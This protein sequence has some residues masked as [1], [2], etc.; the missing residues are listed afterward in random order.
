VVVADGPFRGLN[1]IYGGTSAHER[2]LVLVNVLGASCPGEIAA[3]LV[4]AR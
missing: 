1:A 3:G 4:I 2:E